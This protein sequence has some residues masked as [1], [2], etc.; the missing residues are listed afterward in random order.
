MNTSETALVHIRTPTF[1]RPTELKRCL[2]SIQAQSHENW[3]CDVYDDDLEGSALVVVN[4]LDD[5]RIIHHQNEQQYYASKNIDLCFTRKNPHSADYF[6]VVEDDNSILPTFI[7]ENIRLCRENDVE[8]IFRNQFIEHESGTEQA[9]LS[10]NGILDRKLNEGRYDSD[11]FRL[12][13]VADIG[14]SNGGLFWSDGVV[15]DLEIHFDCSATLQEYLRTFAIDEPIYIA[16]EPLAVWAENGDD[17]TRDLGVNSGYLRSELDLKR[18]I[19]ILQHKAWARAKSSD[20]S[21]FLG[22]PIFAYSTQARARGLVKS[23]LKLNIGNSLP[24]SEKLWL[25]Y[26]GCLIR[27]FGRPEPGLIKFLKT[28]GA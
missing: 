19:R 18:S 6:C 13:L 26:R 17:T 22:H 12:A 21:S 20:S 8:I 28:R 9:Y 14:V 2:Q 7:K 23:H 27:L 3:V 5:P 16:M 11:L 24:F 4:G 25:I 10:E 1:K 15:S